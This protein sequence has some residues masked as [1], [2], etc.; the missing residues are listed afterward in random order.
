M[1]L[2]IGL[3]NEL[4]KEK[5]SE[6]LPGGILESFGRLFRCGVNLLV[7]PWKKQSN[8]ELVTAENFR[9]PDHLRHLYAHF[10]DRGLVKGIPCSDEELLE[11]TG[12]DILRRAKNGKNWK[13]FVPRE[14]Q[15]LVQATVARV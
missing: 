14:A 4:F 1:V 7:Y 13:D 12:R 10:L 9:A 6:N 5:W 8:G 15:H 2:S 3:L 11:T